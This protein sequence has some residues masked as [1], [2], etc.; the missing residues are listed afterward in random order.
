MFW[1]C[2]DRVLLTTVSVVNFYLKLLGIKVIGTHFAI[3][4]HIK[5]FSALGMPIL[6]K[7]ACRIE[8]AASAFLKTFG[9][10]LLA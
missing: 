7:I 4:K 5:T 8:P 10:Q 6:N 9:I 1:N 3:R 2:L